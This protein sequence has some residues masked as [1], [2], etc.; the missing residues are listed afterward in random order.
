MIRELTWMPAALRTAG[1]KVSEEQGWLTRGRGAMREVR[2]VMCH[3]TATV[4]FADRNMPTLRVLKEGT[5]RISGPLSQLALGRD[6]TFYVVA[7]GRSNHAGEGQW[8]GIGKD[9]GNHH[10][11]GIEAEND[12]LDSGNWPDVQMDAYRRGVAA[13]LNH[14]GVDTRWCIGHREYAPGRKPDPNFDMEVFRRQ[15]AAIRA[16]AGATRPL[17]PAASPA[18]RATIRRGDRGEAVKALQLHLKDHL[19]LD[20]M[21]TDGLFGPVTEARVRQFQRKHD[22][23][24]DGIVGPKTWTALE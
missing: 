2:G 3:H 10:F 9:M 7:A 15:V 19:A 13:L 12:G 22:L 11:I 20:S 16:G 4:G 17:I 18:G 6:G 8:P 5:S 1:L 21:V 24:P 23:V 14:L